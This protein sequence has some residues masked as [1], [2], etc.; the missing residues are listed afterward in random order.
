MVEHPKPNGGVASPHWLKRFRWNSLSQQTLFH[1]LRERLIAFVNKTKIF[2][3][4]LSRFVHERKFVGLFPPLENSFHKTTRRYLVCSRHFLSVCFLLSKTLST[5][6]RGA[7]LCAHNIFYL[8][9]PDKPCKLHKKPFSLGSEEKEYEC[10][11]DEETLHK[12]FQ[13]F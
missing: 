9:S 5:K 10:E 7:I 13:F 12:T 6:P 8:P 1:A 3:L 4:T 11:R 2:S